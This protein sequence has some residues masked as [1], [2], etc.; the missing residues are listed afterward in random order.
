M[1]ILNQ[2]MAD[3]CKTC[4]LPQDLCACVELDKEEV[5]IIIRLEKR[6]FNKDTTLIEGFSKGT[7]INTVVKH[8]KNKL[9][10]GG[11][12]KDGCI[13]LQGD[14]RDNA[15]KYLTELGFNE[16]VIEVH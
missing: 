11:T 1:H 12:V 5:K 2:Y 9:A 16:N 7:N 3:I 8:L 10:C 4:G 6:R 14:H 15:K 13:I